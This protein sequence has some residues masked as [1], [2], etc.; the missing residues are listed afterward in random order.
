VSRTPGAHKDQ[1]QFILC[2]LRKL[3]SFIVLAPF[4]A[5]V[6]SP[7]KRGVL[8]ALRINLQI[9][10]SSREISPVNAVVHFTSLLRPLTSVTQFTFV[11]Q[12]ESFINLVLFGLKHVIALGAEP[13]AFKL[14]CICSADL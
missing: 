3:H 5:K 14:A 6:S 2:H 10:S 8:N 9:F 7:S 11:L 12:H 13:H 4:A 1:I